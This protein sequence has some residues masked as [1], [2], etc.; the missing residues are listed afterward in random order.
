MSAADFRRT[1][2]REDG[3]DRRQ[4]WLRRLHLDLPLLVLVLLTAAYGLVVLY[5]ALDGDSVAFQGQLSRLAVAFVMMLIVAQLDIAMLQRWAPVLYGLG[6]VMLVLVLLVGVQAKGAQ[7]WL[8][9]PGLPRFQPSELMKLAV[10]LMVASSLADRPLPPT[11]KTVAWVLALIVAPALLIALQPDLGTAILVAAAG[12]AVLLLSGLFWRWV[13]LAGLLGLAAL[14]G[15]WMVMR[16]YQ[17]QRVLTLLDPESDPLGAGWN[18]I[19]SK[20]AIGSGGLFGKGLFEGTQSHLNFLPESH[21][22]FILAVLA[23][24]LG[25]LGVLGLL[26]LYYLLLTRGLYIATQ[27]RD[28]FARLLAG[29]L[30]LT[31]FTYL[32]VNVAMVSGLAPVV[33]VPLPLVSY[34]GTSALTLLAGFGV[35]MA[36]AT[37]PKPVAA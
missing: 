13:L 9:V 4:R 18:I 37:Q 12:F 10:P 8:G 33:G 1:L 14:P 27:G 5:S 24:E 17:R 25:F 6:I 28:T 7:R 19:Q 29:G 3:F 32:F 31:F 30:T 34:G 21:T 22:D 36:V 26:T 20:I 11:G 35:L 15:L 16:D 23:E 2:S